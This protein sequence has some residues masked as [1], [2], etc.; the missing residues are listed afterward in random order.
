MWAFEAAV[1]FS[2]AG[3]QVGRERLLA[4]RAD[5]FLRAFV[6]GEVGHTLTVPGCLGLGQVEAVRVQRCSLRNR[7]LAPRRAEMDQT[8][9]AFAVR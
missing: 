1:A 2:L 7:R 8:E 5:D 4:V 3:D 9:E 6:G